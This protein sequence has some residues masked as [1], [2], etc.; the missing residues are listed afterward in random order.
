MGEIRNAKITGTTLGYEDHG[1]LTCFLHLDYGDSGQGFGGWT[2]DNPV[3][4]SEG[5]FI[6]RVGTEAGMMFIKE[7]IDVLEV[8]S[9]E[10]LKGEYIRVECDH[11]KVYRIGH[12]IKD[13]WFDPKDIGFK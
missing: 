7:V 4:D 13:N 12:I 3:K 6:N 11:M 8:K 9:W 10:K 1:I 5:K 2:L